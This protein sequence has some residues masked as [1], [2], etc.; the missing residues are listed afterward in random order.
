MGGEW[1]MLVEA[2]GQLVQACGLFLLG[3]APGV[4]PL[5]EPYHLA[6]TIFFFFLFKLL[7]FELLNYSFCFKII[8][9]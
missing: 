6:D 5:P 2:R 4:G 9:V 8:M 7:S 3:G 1:D